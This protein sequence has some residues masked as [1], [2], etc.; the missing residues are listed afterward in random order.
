VCAEVAVVIAV[1]V[2]LQLPATLAGSMLTVAAPFLC[3]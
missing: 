1:I 2:L 3:G